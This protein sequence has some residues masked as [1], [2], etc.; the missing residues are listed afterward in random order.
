[1]NV[2]ISRLQPY[3][4]ELRHTYTTTEGFEQWY[5]LTSDWHW[6]NPKCNRELLR[7]H[8]NQAKERNAKILVFGDLFCARYVVR[9]PLTRAFYTVNNSA[10][11][12]VKY[13][14][15]TK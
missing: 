12:G 11:R 7:K 6:D 5:L 9:G 1:M 2:S 3:A 14:T 8:I 10:F 4:V 13:S 15:L